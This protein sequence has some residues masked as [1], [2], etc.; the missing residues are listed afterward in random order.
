MTDIWKLGLAYEMPSEPVDGMNPVAVAE[1]MDK[2]VNMQEAE[3][4]IFLRNENLSIQRS[5]YE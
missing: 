3:R 2:A 5:F 4:A 1:A